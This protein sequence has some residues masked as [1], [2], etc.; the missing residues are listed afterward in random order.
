M[1]MCG[2]CCWQLCRLA[3]ALAEGV[4]YD[5]GKIL[6]RQTISD[7]PVALTHCF[8][9]NNT[10]GE[11]ILCVVYVGFGIDHMFALSLLSQN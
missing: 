7:R 11:K 10:R 4:D 8:R 9:R 5:R 3:L 2:G 1:E 6:F